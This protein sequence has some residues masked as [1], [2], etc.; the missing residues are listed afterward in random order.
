M[1]LRQRLS[2]P[3]AMTGVR[4]ARPDAFEKG[5][6]RGRTSREFAERSTVPV[7]NRLRAVDAVLGQMRHQAE[8]EWQVASRDALLIERQDEGPRGGVQQEVGI[9]DPLGD[10]LVGQEV[11]EVV[12]AQIR[13]KL[14]GGDIGVDRHELYAASGRTERGSGKNSFSSAADTVSTCNS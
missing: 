6:D 11:A 5:D 14:V 3:R 7:L 2:N 13:G 12:L 9:L 1:H 4:L 8:K 10:A